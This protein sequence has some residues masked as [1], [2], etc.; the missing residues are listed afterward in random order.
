MHPWPRL[1]QIEFPQ[2]NSPT[3]LSSEPWVLSIPAQPTCLSQPPL[4]QAKAALA[5]WPGA[6]NPNTKWL[7]DLGQVAS[8]LQVSLLERKS[9]CSYLACSTD[10]DGASLGWSL[11]GWSHQH[12]SLCPNLG[13]QAI[14]KA[15]TVP[16]PHH[17]QTCLWPVIGPESPSSPALILTH[18]SWRGRRWQVSFEE[19]C[20]SGRQG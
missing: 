7:C 11:A 4:G 17:Q 10:S 15:A 19:S 12:L 5:I 20:G 3:L 18:W 9:A 2:R 13:L 1:R 6:G 16:M 14:S 8:S